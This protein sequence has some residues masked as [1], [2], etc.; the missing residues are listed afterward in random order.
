MVISG[1]IHEYQHLGENIV[2]P[3]S[4]I[5]HAFDEPPSKSLLVVHLTNESIH[6]ER[7]YVTVPIYYTYQLTADHVDTYTLPSLPPL[8]EIKL[9]LKGSQSDIKAWNKSSKIREWRQRGVKIQFHRLAESIERSKGA[10]L[11]G[12]WKAISFSQQLRDLVSP[13]EGLSRC[14]ASL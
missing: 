13:D 4:P 5:Q 2:Y 1:H 11:D 10:S 14:L 7:W 6:H 3:G 12:E 9:I 8:S